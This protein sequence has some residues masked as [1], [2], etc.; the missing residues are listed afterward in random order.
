MK[1][2]TAILALTCLAHAGCAMYYHVM[3][4]PKSDYF[5]PEERVILEKT[6]RAIDFGAAFDEEILLD[7]VFSRTPGFDSF[8]GGEKDLAG[9]IEGL[10]GDTLMAYNEKI[11][12]LKLL[13]AM[14]MEQ[15]RRDGNWK[16]YTYISTYLM[17]ALDHY[18]ALVEQQ[19]AK[20][21]RGYRDFLEERKSDIQRSIDL[22]LRRVEFNELWEYDYDS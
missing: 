19:A 7:Y 22:E 10:D 12:R 9:A 20:R 13:T 14:K 18:A 11:Y 8:K 2:R 15:Y 6:T 17:P 3:P 4:R 16:Q 1:I 21:V 5:A